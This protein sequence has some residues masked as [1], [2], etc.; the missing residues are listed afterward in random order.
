M[1][2]ILKHIITGLSFLVLTLK[3]AF[4]Q[5][6]PQNNN[7][8]ANNSL[9]EHLLMDFGWK[10][11]FGHAFDPKKD[12]NNGTGYFSY[13]TKT[14]YGDGLLLKISMTGRGGYSIFLTIGL[15]NCHLAPMPVIAMVIK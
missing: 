12:F 4:S 7:L 1:K 8:S 5:P 11:A 15:L 2:F 3:I 14:G 9:R 6:A 13:Y 10:F